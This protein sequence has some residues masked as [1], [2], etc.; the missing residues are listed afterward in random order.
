MQRHA[1][2]E[3]L[4]ILDSVS[5]TEALYVIPEQLLEALEHRIRGWFHDD[6]MELERAFTCHC[7]DRHAI[8]LFQRQWVRHLF[9][10]LPGMPTLSDDLFQ[11]LGW[12]AYGTRETLEQQ[13]HQA[14]ELVQPVFEQLEAFMGW[15]LTNPIFLTERD[16]LRAQ[17]QDAVVH[18]G[19][20]PPAPVQSNLEQRGFLPDRQGCSME[21]LAAALTAFYERW[22]FTA[23][24]TW[25]LP[26]P[27]GVNLGGPASVGQFIGVAD[28]PVIQ[29]PPTV[30][31]PTRYPLRDL[32]HGR[33]DVQ[34]AD[35]QAVLEQRHPN[36][37]N[38]VRWGR[39]VQL[40]FWRNVVLEGSYRDRFRGRAG[41]L[42]WVFADYFGDDSD[43]SV[44]KLRLWINRRIHHAQP[45]QPSRGRTR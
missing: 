31:L 30:K 41:A 6:E 23:L 26:Q 4:A 7:R 9:F 3:S 32:I 20:I 33:P 21:A 44:R 37:F 12:E 2:D 17:W 5:R 22:Q 27:K 14:A 18:L 35:W 40:H 28:R 42:D 13:I 45:G 43:E 25:D 8:A 39:I 10:Q 34:L 36:H 29:L 24:S 1:P 15:L 11:Q 16:A 38:F 19:G